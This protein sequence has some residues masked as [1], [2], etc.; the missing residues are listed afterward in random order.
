MDKKLRDTIFLWVEIMISK[1]QVKGKLCHVVQIRFC[2]LRLTWCLPR[3]L[4]AYPQKNYATVDTT[5][6]IWVVFNY[7]ISLVITYSFLV[8]SIWSN[9]SRNSDWFSHVL[10]YHLPGVEWPS[11]KWY[12]LIQLVQ[13][14][15]RLAFFPASRGFFLPSRGFFLQEF[16]HV[17][18]RL[19]IFPS[20]LCTC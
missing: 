3:Y 12:L 13:A 1:R 5:F 6:Y 17:H 16:F 14:F 18:R 7:V 15:F 4:R 10:S 20:C 8:I 9:V 2:R 11:L 19:L